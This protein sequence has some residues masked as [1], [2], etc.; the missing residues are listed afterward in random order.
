MKDVIERAI[1]LL[2]N[3]FNLP[4]KGFLAGGALCNTINKIIFGG[5]VVINDIDIFILD[6]IKNIDKID[7]SDTYNNKSLRAYI[8]KEQEFE[9]LEYDN[10]TTYINRKTIGVNYNIIKSS[11]REDI[12]NFINYESSSDDYTFLLETFDINCCQVGYDLE[13]KKAFWTKDFSEYCKTKE[14]KVSLPNTPSHTALRI[15][16]KRDE[17]GAI[18]NIDNEFNFLKNA[19]LQYIYGLK[20][21]WFSD[22]YFNIYQ[23]YESE[24]TKYFTLLTNK[25]ETYTSYRLYPINWEIHQF[26]NGCVEKNHAEMTHFINSLKSNMSIEQY[27]YYWRNIKTNKYKNLIWEKLQSFYKTDEYLDNIVVDDIDVDFYHKIVEFEQYLKKYPFMNK[28]FKDISL[29]KQLEILGWFKKLISK[30]SNIEKLLSIN[31]KSFNIESEE[32]L[33]DMCIILKLY[34]RKNLNIKVEDNKNFDL[35][36][37]F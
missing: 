10:L 2:D 19:N 4:D 3:K 29:I 9:V 18:L 14:L 35:F 32:D 34:Y 13:N 7:D 24:I 26:N 15:L 20:R 37:I 8:K 12:F 33:E 6:E 27:T 5:N 31:T 30:D 23:K 1:K 25:K 11:N 21:Y 16:K 17:L 36:D 28:S 22:K